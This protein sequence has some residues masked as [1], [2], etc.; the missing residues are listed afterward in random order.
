MSSS[1]PPTL[2]EV[3]HL[4]NVSI[5]TASRVLN[6]GPR[7]PTEDSRRRVLA[8]A[9]RLD[10]RPNAAARAVAI[11]RGNTVGLIVHDITD[12]YFSAV[13][14]SVLE[15][16]EKLG[17]TTTVADARSQ[18]DRESDLLALLHEQRVRAVV[19]VGSRT[20]DKEQQRRLKREISA[21]SS[22]GGR[23]V[24]I[25]ERIPDVDSVTVENAA[26]ARALADALWHLGHRS[27]VVLSGPTN[28]RSSSDRVRGFKR[29]LAEKGCELT[30]DRVFVDA[31]QRDG[32][33]HAAGRW[34]E[35]GIPATCI[36]AANDVMAVGATAALR[37]RGFTLPADV[38]IAGFDDIPSL[39]DFTPAL[40]TVRIP[41][42]SLGVHAID[43]A[44]KNENPAPTTRY[45][46]GEV[47]LRD[48]TTDLSVIN[49]S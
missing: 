42:E 15:A 24:M 40:T 36:F 19:I 11:G 16:A 22:G 4:A 29:G 44:L 3:A 21:F 12:P 8:A 10:Y 34:A 14:A 46:A 37:E 35:S 48:S 6:G 28:V 47:V 1:S 31:F 7:R 43:L 45:F 23:V 41:L 17:A 30:R 38:S 2:L 9:E 5:A 18:P 27:F 13:A 20:T 32:G 39:R 26:G 25:S 49:P 33:F